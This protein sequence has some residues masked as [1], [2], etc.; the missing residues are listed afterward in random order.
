MKSCI[1]WDPREY[2][3]KAKNSCSSSLPASPASW[4]QQGAP[5][6]AS[7]GETAQKYPDGTFWVSCPFPRACPHHRSCFGWL[8]AGAGWEAASASLRG[9]PVPGQEESTTRRELELRAECTKSQLG[10]G[11]EQILFN[12]AKPWLVRNRKHLEKRKLYKRD[13]MSKGD[14]SKGNLTKGKKKK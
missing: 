3:T 1:Q 6:A 4:G 8:W 9:Q 14:G 2:S 7:A 10:R 5:A 13:Y 12:S 11:K